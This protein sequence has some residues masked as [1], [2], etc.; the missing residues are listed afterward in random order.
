MNSTVAFWA[1]IF[2]V[3]F[4]IG[5]LIGHNHGKKGYNELVE[6]EKS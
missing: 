3:G 5:Y 2:I 4:I 1:L 6:E